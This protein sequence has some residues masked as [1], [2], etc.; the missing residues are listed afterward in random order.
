MGKVKF[1]EGYRFIGLVVVPAIVISFTAFT[2][3]SMVLTVLLSEQ[4][5]LI[6]I[7]KA[8]NKELG[9]SAQA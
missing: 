8:I 2:V 6:N 4:G 3:S 9:N 1:C 5:K 7:I